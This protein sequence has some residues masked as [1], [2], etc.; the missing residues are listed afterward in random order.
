MIERYRTGTADV[1]EALAGI[2]DEELD[3]QPAEPDGWTARQV[4]HHLA[5]SEAMAYIRLRRLIAEDD[6]VIAGYDEPEWARRLHYDRPIALVGRGPARPSGPA[7]LELL[8][9]LTTDEWTP[10]RHPQRVRARTASRTGSGSTPATRTSTPT[11]SGPRAAAE[12]ALGRR[13][14]AVGRGR[15]EGGHRRERRVRVRIGGGVA[16]APGPVVAAVDPD[17]S[18]AEPLRRHVVVEQALGDVQDPGRRDAVARASR[19]PQRLEVVRV[20]LVRADLLGRHDPVEL[21][22]EPAVRRGEQVVVAVRQDAEPEA[23]LE[24]VE[25]SG[26]VR[27]RRPVADRAAERA[28]RRR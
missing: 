10:D 17:E 3:R 1:E 9:A 15:R 18:E 22:A 4:A 7:S 12:P 5:D 2:T 13:G 14:L 6:P 24:P 23:R 25:R 19:S 26:R 16:P 28:P 8:E 27:E 21:D 20:R 11:R